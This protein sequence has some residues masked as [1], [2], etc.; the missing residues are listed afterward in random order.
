MKD[1]NGQAVAEAEAEVSDVVVGW[2]QGTPYHPHCE[3]ARHTRLLPF[4][5]AQQLGCLVTPIVT[6]HS[7]RRLQ[8]ATVDGYDE[9]LV[10]VE[11]R[12]KGLV[13]E[14]ENDEQVPGQ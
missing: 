5:R 10:E 1:E 6:K 9:V 4:Q 12:R 3:W 7:D 11:A 2:E 8:E 13:E 14:E